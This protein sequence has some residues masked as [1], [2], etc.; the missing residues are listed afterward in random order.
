M[1][2]TIKTAIDHAS[3]MTMMGLGGTAVLFSIYAVA[4]LVLVEG[5]KNRFSAVIENR[6]LTRTSDLNSGRTL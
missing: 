6:L 2:N 4:A 3:Q 5:A 1:I